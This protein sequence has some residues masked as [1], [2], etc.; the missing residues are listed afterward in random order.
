MGH[1]FVILFYGVHRGVTFVG[2]EGRAGIASGLG[3]EDQ[4]ISAQW[5]QTFRT[6]A[7]DGDDGILATGRCLVLL[8]PN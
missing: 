4:R 2:T 7:A 6:V 1:Y 8:G 3:H 5:L